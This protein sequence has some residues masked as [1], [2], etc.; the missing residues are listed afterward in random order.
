VGVVR[1]R[2]DS[3][4]KLAPGLG[5][6]RSTR[7]GKSGDCLSVLTVDADFTGTTHPTGWL[8][9]FPTGWPWDFA[10]P[11]PF[12]GS[13]ALHRP[14]PDGSCGLGPTHRRSEGSPLAGRCITGGDVNPTCLPALSRRLVPGS[15]ASSGFRH[16]S[17]APCGAVAGRRL[18]PCPLFPCF[19]RPL[20]SVG[21]RTPCQEPFPL[22][23]T[24]FSLDD[25]RNY[26]RCTQNPDGFSTSG[27]SLIHGGAQVESD[28][29]VGRCTRWWIR[30][31]GGKCP[32][33]K[34]E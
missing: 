29:H 8:G 26:T 10:F 20:D 33:T 24:D 23:P 31:G 34:P 1:Y 27:I 16:W 22:S 6:P 4:G 3:V 9:G 28:A 30:C 17:R 13:A 25:R 18:P 32:M 5:P 21:S 11:D 15:P 12:L 14:L 7:H 2:T 19:A